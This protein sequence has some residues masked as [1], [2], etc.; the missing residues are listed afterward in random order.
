[1]KKKTLLFY[2]N[3]FTLIFRIFYSIWWYSLGNYSLYIPMICARIKASPKSFLI[4][5]AI[6]LI[7]FGTFMRRS[8]IV[9]VQKEPICRMIHF[10]L[11]SAIRSYGLKWC[12][13]ISL[14]DH[15]RLFSPKLNFSAQLFIQRMHLELCLSLD[16]KYIK[17]NCFHIQRFTKILW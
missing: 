17:C 9:L 5:L 3:K 16:R 2:I 1:M 10:S 15:Y 11:L 12:M 4:H 13:L 8:L 14:S 6:I 7:L